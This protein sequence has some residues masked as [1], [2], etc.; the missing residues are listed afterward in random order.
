MMPLALADRGKEYLVRRL[1]GQGETRQHLE[2]LG[3]TPGSQVKIINC[4]GGNLIVQVR[5]SRIAIDETMARKI[6]V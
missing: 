3:F 5:Q 2:D 6:M 4:L 1:S